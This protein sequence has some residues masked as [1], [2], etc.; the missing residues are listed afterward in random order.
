MRIHGIPRREYVNGDSLLFESIFSNE[1]KFNGAI[2][3]PGRIL[4]AANIQERFERPKDKS[5]WR[6]TVTSLLQSA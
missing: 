2:I 3:Y 5:E 4:H 6:L 1:L